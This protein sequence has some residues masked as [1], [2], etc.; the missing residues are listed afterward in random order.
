[1][2]RNKYRTESGSDRVVAKLG[3]FSSQC[4]QTTNTLDQLIPALSGDPV[5][6]AP[7]SV[8][9]DHDGSFLLVSKT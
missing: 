9:V 2:G 1:V 4:R 6:T 8:F 3:F 5:A 7:G